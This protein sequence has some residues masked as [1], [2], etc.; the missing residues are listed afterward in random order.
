MPPGGSP[1][2]LADALVG[3]RRRRSR[4]WPRAGTA[5][6]VALA[7][8]VNLLDVDTVV[9]GGIYAPLLALAA[10]R[11][12]GGDSPPGAHRRLVA[13]ARCGPRRSALGRGDAGR[14]RLG[15]PGGPRRPG[16]RW[17]S[18]HEPAL[19]PSRRSGG[20]GRRLGLGLATVASNSVSPRSSAARP[21]GDIRS[22]TAA[23]RRRRSRAARRA[24]AGRPA[25]G[26]ARSP[27]GRPARHPL[28]T[29]R[30]PPAGRTAGWPRTGSSQ[31]RGQAAQVDARRS[32]STTSS[33]C[34]W[35]PDSRGVGRSRAASHTDSRAS[36]A[37]SSTPRPHRVRP[38]RP[39]V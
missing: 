30:R 37:A 1:D 21:A 32:A 35:G 29:A 16:A 39:M 10:R 5:L 26:T 3:R 14:G 11:R 19:R 20:R 31:L 25:S 7:G 34:S 2:L 12:R 13:G 6:G 23:I 17:L 4:R 9:L 36:A 27:A 33:A 38:V 28:D 8:V 15:D 22:S 24:A 18:R